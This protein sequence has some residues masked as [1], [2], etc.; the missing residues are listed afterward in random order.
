VAGSSKAA[1]PGAQAPQGA[2]DAAPRQRLNRPAILAAATRLIERDGL[3]A[4]SM[5]RLGGE[6]DVQ[7]MALYHHLP[8]RDSLIDGVVDLAID[9]LYA[10]P[11]V[12]LTPDGG[13]QDYL[14][15]LAHGQ[16]AHSARPPP[17]VPAGGHPAPGRP[18]GPAAA[19]QPALDRVLPF[20]AERRGLLRRHCRL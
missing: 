9:E 17:P 19:S 5:R 12:L 2:A 3:A 15:R 20:R 14:R 6:L 8:N 16:P 13:W 4:L 18:V 1:E 11:E 7:A 10:D